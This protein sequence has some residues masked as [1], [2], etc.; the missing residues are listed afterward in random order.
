[1]SVMGRLG[2]MIDMC[3]RWPKEIEMTRHFASIWQKGDDKKW[4][5]KYFCHY[6]LPEELE[7]LFLKQN[8]KM[9]DRVGL[10]GFSHVPKKTNALANKY[11][12]AGDN[13]LKAHWQYCNHPAIYATSGHMMLVGR[14]EK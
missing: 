1:M 10:E 5:R 14:K 7:N 11:L 12:R 2:V 3:L 9:I 13:W 4:N 8:I 6:F